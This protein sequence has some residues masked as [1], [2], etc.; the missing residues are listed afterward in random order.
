MRI[1]HLWFLAVEIIP[2]FLIFSLSFDPLSA[3][4]FMIVELVIR[5]RQKANRPKPGGGEVI[6]M[7]RLKAISIIIT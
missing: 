4:S 3:L 7:K 5:Y 6:V 1:N 2:Q